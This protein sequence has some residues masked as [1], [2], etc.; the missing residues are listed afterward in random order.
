MTVMLNHALRWSH[1]RGNR[2]VLSGWQATQ[3]DPPVR[4]H[5]ISRAPTMGPGSGSH[6]VQ[7][8]NF[9]KGDAN[10]NSC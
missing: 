8:N 2:V 7:V 5:D 10:L 6:W 3:H 9:R 4:K 1:A